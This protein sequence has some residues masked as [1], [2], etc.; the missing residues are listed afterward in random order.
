MLNS[1]SEKASDAE[2][3]P[4]LDGN[5][6]GNGSEVSPDNRQNALR[7]LVGF[8]IGLLTSLLLAVSVGCV[9]ALNRNVPDFELVFGGKLCL[10]IF[11]L[12]HY[13]YKCESTLS[14]VLGNSTA[15]SNVTKYVRLLS[16]AK[17]TALLFAA[18]PRMCVL[19]TRL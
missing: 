16:P 13:L 4:L 1:V 2:S 10:F 11:L 7:S 17:Q 5:G 9:Q 12:P 18:V 6:S 3:V 8:L 15:G 14:V 19:L